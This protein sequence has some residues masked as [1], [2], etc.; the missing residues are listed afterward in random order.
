VYETESELQD[1][2]RLLDASGERVGPH[3]ASIFSKD[4][5]LSARQ[6]STYLQ[7]VKQVAAAVVN[8]EGEP[9]VAPI[10]AVLFHGRFYLSTA[11]SSVRARSLL[12]KPSISLTYF[13]NAQPMI[14][15]HGRAAFVRKEDDQFALLDNEWK[16]AY[17]AST[18]ELSDTVLFVRV[19][20]ERMLA[21]A[22]H[23]ERLPEA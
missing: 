21:Y 17:G 22:F 2:Q 19:E 14:I 16:K 4:K 11:S 1:M 6:V 12:R 5:R 23:P 7:G 8:S 9:R 10:D 20:P 13:E 3:L 15:V 18:L